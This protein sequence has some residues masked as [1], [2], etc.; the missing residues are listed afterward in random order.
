[1]SNAALAGCV[2]AVT[3]LMLAASDG[4]VQPRQEMNRVRKRGRQEPDQ[5]RGYNRAR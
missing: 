5:Y 3:A 2:P 1:M 4:S